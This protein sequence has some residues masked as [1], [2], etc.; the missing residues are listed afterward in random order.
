MFLEFLNKARNF[1]KCKIAT[2][3]KIDPKFLL[4]I[5]FDSDSQ[6]LLENTRT[7]VGSSWCPLLE[8]GKGN[9][10]TCCRDC[11][12]KF[13][14]EARLLPKV[15]SS[16]EGSII[17]SN[18]PLWLQQYKEENKRS[19]RNDKVIEELINIYSSLT[20]HNTISTK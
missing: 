2:A 12:I 6:S 4:S 3:R 7:G 11:S 17:T 14:N 5:P 13:E 10:L 16:S 9:Q 15:S 20:Q 19:S 1:S 18:L 8:D